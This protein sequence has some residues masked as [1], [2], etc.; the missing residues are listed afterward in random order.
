MLP[1][2]PTPL[3]SLKLQLMLTSKLKELQIFLAQEASQDVE[4][5][6]IF[7]NVKELSGIYKMVVLLTHQRC[8][9]VKVVS[10]KLMVRFPALM[11]H[12]ETQSLARQ[13]NASAN[14]RVLRVHLRLKNVPKKEKTANAKVMYSMAMP[15]ME[16]LS[17]FSQVQLD[18]IPMLSSKFSLEVLSNVT[19]LS[20]EMLQMEKQSNASVLN[21]SMRFTN[22][23]K[24]LSQRSVLMKVVNAIA[25]QP[26]ILVS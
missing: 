7:V 16:N 8:P 5:K 25:Q 11:K 18:R 4:K 20:S 2:P 21:Q 3:L 23:R 19:I 17:K 9:M 12:S 10:N 15:K 6:A 24:N 26:F 22:S 1:T 14:Q 13:N